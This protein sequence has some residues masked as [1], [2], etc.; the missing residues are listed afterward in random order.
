MDTELFMECEEEEL[1]PWQQVDASV[2][3]D[4]VDYVSSSPSSLMPPPLPPSSSATPLVSQATP[5][6]LTQTNRGA[7]FLPAAPGT[8]T[9]LLLTAQGFPLQGTRPGSSLVLNLP[10]GQPVTPL[11]LIHTPPVGAL[12]RP[13]VGMASAPPQ[14]RPSS[15]LTGV[16]TEPASLHLPAALTIHPSKAGHVSLY[17]SQMGGAK[18]SESSG[19]ID[20]MPPCSSMTAPGPSPLKGSLPSG[21][22]APGRRKVVLSVD[23]FYYGT[24]EGSQGGRGPHPLGVKASSFTCQ[25]CSQP[26]NNNL[27]LVQHTLQHS[28]LVRGGD[29][30]KLCT[31]CFRQFSSPAQLQSHRE[32][33]HGPAPSPSTC[34]ICEW[35]FDNES[36]FL[37][38][39]KSNHKPGE[40]P[41]VCKV[42]SYR[43]SFYSDVLQHFA[44]FH[45][46]LRCLLCVFCLKV[47]RN[48]ANYQ[49]HVLRHKVSQ[50]FHC[51][52]CR[53]QFVFL[54][55]KTQH[56]LEDHHSVRRPAKLEGL[57]LGSKVTIRMY[58]KKRPPMSWVR[59]AAQLLQN[60]S[61]LIQPIRIKTEQQN[62]STPRSLSTPP[63]S[64]PVRPTGVH[65][66][67]LVCL[68][69]GSEASDLPAH[70]PTHVRCVL[71]AYSSCC[72]RAYAAHM[73]HHHVP[74]TKGEAL[75]LHRMSPPCPFTLR[76]SLCDFTSLSADKMA[77]HLVINPEHHSATCR[78]RIYIESDIQLC[79]D[80]EAPKSAEGVDSVQ[81]E[82]WRSVD[83]WKQPLENSSRKS[84]V[85][86]FKQA[87]GP[88]HPLQQNSDAI[89]FFNLMFPAALVELI[90]TETN[91][92][93]KTCQYLG[94]GCPDWIPATTHEIKGFIGL[95]I[96]MGIQNLP[97]LAQYWSCNDH[98]NSRTFQHTM[99]LARFKQLAS[100][101][102]MG[103][104]TTDEYRRTGNPNDSLHIFR[105]MLDVLGGSMWDAYRPNCCL[106]IDR[107]LL[108]RLE[109]DGVLGTG[110]SKSQPQVWLLCDSKSG[111][112]HHFFI[113]T[114]EKL[115]QEAGFT[116]VME[117]VKG[118]ED[119]HH[120]LYLANSLTSVPL[121]QKLLERGVY[122]SSS[123]P[124]LSHI[125]PKG[126]WEEGR[127]DKPGD[128][129]QRSLGPLL[130]TRWKDT[131][132]M[133]CLSTNADAGK[134]D[135]VWRRSQTKVGALEPMN[136]P[137]AFRLL[138]ENMRGVDICKQLL[139]CNPLGGILQDRHWRSLFWF[140]VNL[141]VVN[142]FIVLRE[143]RKE[144]PPA[145]VHNGLFMQ[146]NFR[147]QLGCQL[148]DCVRGSSGAASWHLP[149]AEGT[150]KT[151]QRHRL[152]KIGSASKRCRNCNVKNIRHETVY[153]CVVCRIN[154][155]KQ[156]RCFWEFH[157]L[158]P[159]NKG[160]TK[161]GF[162]K[163]AQSGEVEA[164]EVQDH[165]AP[166]EDFSED[167]GVDELE[168]NTLIKE[169]KPASQSPSPCPED[170][171][172][173]SAASIP[174]EQQD[175]LSPQ[176]LQVALLALCGGLRR[177]SC[178]FSTEPQLIR[179]WLKEARKRL[180]PR[181]ED[182]YGEG[183]AGMVAWVLS[184]REQQIPISESNLFR[185][186]SVLKKNGAFG[187]SFQISCDWAVRF[188]LRYKLGPSDAGGRSVLPPSLEA[189][190]RSFRAFTQ[191]VVRVHEL[192]EG[193][194]ALVDEFCLFLDFTGVPE[195][196]KR[197]EALQFTGS[198]PVVTVYLTL[199]A[200]GTMLPALVL[201]NRK[202]AHKVLTDFVLLE[203]HLES[204]SAGDAFKIWTKRIWLQYLS[205]PVHHKKSML[206]LDQ[207]Q[208]HTGDVFLGN[209]SGSGTLP[210]VIPAGCSF[211]LQPVLL[212]LKPALQRFLR[213][214]WTEF[215]AG[216]SKELEEASP[217]HL[218]DNV[219]GIL[220]DWVVEALLKLKDLRQ[221]WRKSF[222]L[223]GILPRREH[224][225]D[226]V[227]EGQNRQE[228]Q[229]DLLKSLED[230][231]LPSERG[232]DLGM[233]DNED[234]E[235]DETSAE[236]Q[237]G[238]QEEEPKEK[239][240]ETV[241]CEETKKDGEDK[242]EVK[243][244]EED[245]EEEGKEA[246]DDRMEVTKERRE[247]RIMIGEQVGDEWKIAT[248]TRTE[249]VEPNADE[250]EQ[251]DIAESSNAVLP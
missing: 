117:L 96:L 111:Y 133:G 11:T 3:E 212:C 190:I 21:E 64:P 164:A 245:S 182:A 22:L 141:S 216:N 105:P 71:C 52:R 204:P 67:R 202:P 26:V 140:L 6:I 87:S 199:L 89:D 75:P 158:S 243:T 226:D 184:Q 23:E 48:V 84:C 224:A 221:L 82:D 94:S 62:S 139:A 101:I 112:C 61:S 219:T 192:S 142:A 222:Q 118:L 32:L 201:S 95:C 186:A 248:K 119:K 10:P 97:E 247:T 229:H 147:K 45:R 91:A 200:D 59:G 7:L 19:V 30:K 135:T 149:K 218:Q 189:K 1:E 183:E 107:A 176:Q 124:P 144:T 231:L 187:D 65:G 234:S 74:R 213:C 239:G 20:A 170:D 99:T 129:L 120:Q 109:G 178:V 12:V 60:P 68:E 2:D 29:V 161:V 179:S 151:I 185:K 9:P 44:S 37:N 92:H 8:A 160:S 46:D 180:K 157:G 5:L 238:G 41:Y 162:L 168:E 132:E 104:F 153:G 233:E 106:S 203:T 43:S 114:G 56:K 215:I 33:V 88:H 80:E 39:M 235:D 35:S 57:P 167:E 121:V 156:P 73:I 31:F 154:L 54:K 210:A 36:A 196:S 240:E 177:A 58:S 188:M 209:I 136:R 34:R 225:N 227:E 49:Q 18:A 250:G 40:M 78:I 53:L 191:K 169:E 77:E 55:D 15:A 108:P 47:T 90:A 155:C 127:L 126:L 163:N 38:H 93:V 123:F 76:C 125:L 79:S 232:L 208:E 165:M 115:K 134:A 211:V 193:S 13:V 148:A 103:S 146:V 138:Q 25:V 27:R 51:N 83:C 116:V 214:R 72:S 181:K 14:T 28:P 128:F 230:I 42:C 17:M 241:E 50:A 228:N 197:T 237:D 145:W 251:M 150:D 159:I 102:R 70:F 171:S 205:G 152:A 195:L 110:D 85:L 242:D 63:G 207:H 223:T 69:C 220:L 86:P 131:K 174:N 4:D 236:E 244:L 113:Q 198:S 100:N 16:P 66:T 130:A 194:I 143:S 172:K 175:F 24:L 173:Q 217:C 122:T 166:V 249:G 246:E 137:M 206:V 98:E 81:S